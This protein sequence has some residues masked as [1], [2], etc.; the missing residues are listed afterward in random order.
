MKARIL[1]VLMSLIVVTLPAQAEAVS[2]K[3][4]SATQNTAVDKTQTEKID[5]NKADV[6]ILAGSFK[7]VGKKR[8]EAII[9]YRDSHHGIKSIEELAE[10]KGFGQHFVDTN[11]A[12]LKEIYVIQ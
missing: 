1:A 10:V 12:K 2:K 3:H 4:R 7:G 11:R 9:A 6:S 8:A 5:L